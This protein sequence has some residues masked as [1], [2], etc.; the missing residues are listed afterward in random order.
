[1][2]PNYE[3]SLSLKTPISR[4]TTL[5][6][7]PPR[8]THNGRSRSDRE[9][10]YR[11]F[12]LHKSYVSGISDEQNSDG[13]RSFATCPRRWTVRIDSRLSGPSRSQFSRPRELRFPDDQY[14]DSHA[15]S[16][17]CP[18]RW[19]VQIASRC[20]GISIPMC[21]SPRDSRFPIPDFL[22]ICDTR[23]SNRTAPIVSG[24]RGSRF[25]CARVL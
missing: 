16:A 3:V 25:L 9:I 14:P 10:A 15:I 24:N 18:P 17:T 1:V 23:P 6:D 7:P 12:N 5:R 8:V 11:D 22:Q 13:A 2:I 4:S 20:F 21:L 19:A